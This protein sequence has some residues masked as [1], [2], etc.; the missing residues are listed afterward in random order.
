[1]TKFFFKFKKPYFWPIFRIF[2]AKV[3]PIQG[4]LMTQ[5]QE[6][7]YTGG[8]RE[9]QTDPISQDPSGYCWGSNKDNCSRVTFKSQTYRVRCWSNKKLLHRRFSMQKIRSVH[10]I[11]LKAC[12][13][14]FLKI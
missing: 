12:V 9:G 14:Y 8:R 6:N 13:R 3:F 5:F 11:I 10:T 1:M 4:N 2:G 7:T